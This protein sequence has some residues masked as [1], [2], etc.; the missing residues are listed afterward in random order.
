MRILLTGGT[1]F[2][3]RPLCAALVA[4]G[5]EVTVPSR[6]PETVA[7][8][9]GPQVR[10]MASLAD[11]CEE[12]AF[13]AVI[14]LA[15]EPIADAAWSEARKRALRD[16]RIGTTQQLVAAIA[17]ARQK[18]HVLLSGSAI[19]YYGDTGDRAIDESAPPANDFAAT[20]CRDWEHAALAAESQGVRVCLLRTGLVLDASGGMLGKLLPAFRFGLGAR[21]GDG[22][23]WMSWIALDDY[24]EAVLMLLQNGHARGPWNMTA[25][26]PVTNAEFTRTLARAVHRPAWFS[27]PSSVLKLALGERSPLL[28]GGQRVLPARLLQD[29]FRFRHAD[30]AAALRE[31]ARR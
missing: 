11:W 26:Q 13:D 14:N 30:L 21:L 31:L 22:R 23:Q 20:L 25:P 3:G 7:T 27:A 12:V 17:R 29:G 2:I 6:R 28:L 4:A 8:K 18:P 16:S 19:G 1:G 10:P 5:H 9:C 24:I 15:G